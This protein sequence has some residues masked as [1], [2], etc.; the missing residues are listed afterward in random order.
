M[1]D[2]ARYCPQ[3]GGS[4][5]PGP[6]QS[7]STGGG[8]IHGPAYQAGGDINIGMSSPEPSVEYG[9]SWS[10]RSPLTLAA[11]TWLSVALGV[12]GVVAGWQGLMPLINMLRNGRLPNGPPN[13]SW[14][15]TFV[16]VA[17]LFLIALVLRRVAK[18]RTQH[19]FAL[20]GMPAITGWGGR[21]GLAKFRGRCPICGGNLRFYDKPTHWIEDLQS[22]RRKITARSMAAECVKNEDHWWP[23]DK[24]DGSHEEE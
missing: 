20:P 1:P 12:L 18:H 6:S 4:A 3:C 16:V 19:F 15:I 23:V 2:A 9:A 10:W 8:D 11:L 13:L 14:L 22:G 5:T 17:V 7:F 21:V 24:T